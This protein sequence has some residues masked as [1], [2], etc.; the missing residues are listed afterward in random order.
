MPQR[1][2]PRPAPGGRGA[3]NGARQPRGGR[4]GPG[5]QDPDTPSCD[6]PAGC[7][8]THAALFPHPSHVTNSF[9]HAAMRGGL[10]PSVCSL[11]GSRPPTL[12]SGEGPRPRDTQDKEGLLQRCNPPP[13][14]L[15]T[16]R[17]R[18]Q[19]SESEAQAHRQVGHQALCCPRPRLAGKGR[20]SSQRAARRCVGE[21]TLEGGRGSPKLP[22]AL[23]STA[24]SARVCDAWAPGSQG[25]SEDEV[26]CKQPRPGPL[27]SSLQRWDP[28]SAKAAARHTHTCTQALCTRTYTHTYPAH[29][30]THVPCAHM[31]PR[32]LHTGARTHTP[33]Q[34][35]LQ[36]AQAGAC[37]GERQPPV[38]AL[39]LFRDRL[40]GGREC[41]IGGSSGRS[42]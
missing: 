5:T 16:P 24:M 33:G 1:H 23:G 17:A 7:W 19:A 14:L 38:T 42:R 21:G 18:L 30:C 9:P 26:K 27:T 31:P 25:S 34:P 15:P 12:H 11:P 3:G 39:C 20:K 37:E 35:G 40:P 41:L 2:S 32:N 29:V 36:A 4:A 28:R 6:R 13:S 10:L 8:E 22:P